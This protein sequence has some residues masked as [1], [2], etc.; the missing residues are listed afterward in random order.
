MRIRTGDV[1][2][3]WHDVGVGPPVILIHGLADDHRAWRRVAGEL[4]LDHRVILY[5][6]RG[7]GG[8]SLGTPDGRLAQLG[9]DLL[10]LC[11]ALSLGRCALAGFSL[12]GTIAM[13]AAIDAPERVAGL[14]LVA[15][16]SRVGHAA[17]EWYL[18]RAAMVEQ[19]DPGLRET[20][21]RDTADVYRARPG[22]TAA[23]LHI[24]RAS[25]HDPRGYGNACRAMA[26]LR[27]HPL[28]DE[29][30]RITAP[31]AIL[32]GDADQH[33]PPRAAEIIAQRIGG[34]RLEVLPGAGHPLPVERP[35]EVAEAIRRIT[36]AAG[37]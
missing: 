36:A 7:H 37:A 2:T 12:G 20:L 30:A 8:S 13:R 32:A 35:D 9:A 22:E 3:A 14:A 6:L 11:D 24:R 1:E 10:A 33:C 34:S 31:T 25:T 28:D 19:H 21:D 23:G 16:S 27:E 5:D 17:Q 26:A 18:E 15:T 4:M 29:L